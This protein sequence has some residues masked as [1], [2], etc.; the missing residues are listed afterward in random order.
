MVARIEQLWR[1]GYRDTQIAATLSREGFRSA[2]RAQVSAA[3]VLK[4][5]KHHQWVSRYQQHRF[6][7]KIDAMWTIRGLAGHLDVKRA[8]L[9]NRIRSG[10]LAEPDVI[11]RP[12]Y[13]NY[14][15]R[16]DAELLER[17]RVE[18]RRSRQGE[19]TSPT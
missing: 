18:V 10:F 3:T 4:M 2:R 15:I 16:D 13:G 1:D 14:L 17:L 6:A 7:D 12:P 8:W 19:R 5:R 9:D 11:R